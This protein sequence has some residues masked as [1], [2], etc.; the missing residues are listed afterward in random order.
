M[1]S[2]KYHVGDTIT[3]HLPDGDVSVHILGIQYD[4]DIILNYSNQFDNPLAKLYTIDIEC[5]QGDVGCTRGD[6][7][8]WWLDNVVKVNR[9]DI[10]HANKDV[11]GD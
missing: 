11:G 3:F 10:E 5:M 7:T 4:R 2:W 8:E 1:G 6:V 9:T